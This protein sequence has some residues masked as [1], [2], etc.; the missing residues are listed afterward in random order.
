MPILSKGFEGESP[1]KMQT[2]VA[3]R[4]SGSLQSCSHNST[5]VQIL[6]NVQILNRITIKITGISG[7][8]IQGDIVQILRIERNHV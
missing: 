6:N 5:I 1:L 7:T 8:L 3:K 4:I 2:T